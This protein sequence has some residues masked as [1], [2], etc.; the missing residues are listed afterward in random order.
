MAKQRTTPELRSFL[1]AMDKDTLAV[2]VDISRD[3]KKM[4]GLIKVL[5]LISETDKSR[6]IRKAGGVVSMDTMIYSSVDQSFNRGRISH[7]VLL[8][9]IIKNAGRELEI[10]EETPSKKKSLTK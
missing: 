2:I 7:G 5:N 1:K 8:H 10:R 6:I 9:G 4:N 3:A